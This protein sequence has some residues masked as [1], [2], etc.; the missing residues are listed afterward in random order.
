[1]T[2]IQLAQMIARRTPWKTLT[3]LPAEDANVLVLAMNQALQTWFELANATHVAKLCRTVLHAPVTLTGTAAHD[4][5]EITLEAPPSWVAAEATGS[6]VKV[7]GDGR[8]N[9]LRSPTRL[10]LPYQGATGAVTFVLHQDVA[11]LGGAMVSVAGEV[12]MMRGDGGR[13]DRRLRF[14]DV[15]PCWLRQGAMQGPGEPERCQV[16]SFHPAD[17]GA[18]AFVLR[19][20]PPPA[21]DVTLAYPVVRHWTMTLADLLVPRELPVPEDVA[22]GIVFPLALDRA[23]GQALLTTE[24][25]VQRVQADAAAAEARI[26]T[27][28]MIP[29]TEPAWLGTPAGY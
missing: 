16:E 6:T 5:T 18:P 3:A 10:L 8:W 20:W 19:V 25:D 15:P 28:T 7:S 26:H 23:A 1:M 9:Q 29:M 2:T 13:G 14:D 27:R 11:P 21:Q 24:T 22:A 12:R 4:S 17:D